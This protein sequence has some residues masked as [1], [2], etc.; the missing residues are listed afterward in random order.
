MLRRAE[1]GAHAGGMGTG[2]VGSMV[3]G[4]GH[5]GRSHEPVH[6]NETEH[7]CPYGPRIFES[8]QHAIWLVQRRRLD[9]LAFLKLGHDIEY[10]LLGQQPALDVFLHDA[11]F[12]DEHA[13]R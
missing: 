6:Q 12:I 7:Q 4:M 9:R 13:D 11:F 3:L 5:A 1:P 2:L 10:Q 8:N